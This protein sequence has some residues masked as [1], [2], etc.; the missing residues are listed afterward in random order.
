MAPPKRNNDDSP[1]KFPFSPPAPPP[2]VAGEG[3]GEDITDAGLEDLIAAKAKSG[4]A[5]PPP[6]AL[7]PPARAG[8]RRPSAKEAKEK[9]S[10]KPETVPESEAPKRED[11][12]TCSFPGLLKILFPEKSFVPTPVPV[13]VV[14]LSSGGALVEIHDKSKI[15]RDTPL[16]NRFFELKVA[17]PEI[18]ILRGSIAWSDFSRQNVLLGLSCFE[19]T[20]ELSQLIL[21]S[22]TAAAIM[23]GP[24][25]LPTPV[26]DPFPPVSR[27]ETIVLTGTAPEA[28]EVLVRS[29]ERRFSAKVVKGRFEIKLEIGPQQENHFN[30]RSVAGQRRSRPIPIRIEYDRHT[31]RNRF[32]FNATRGND[33]DGSHIIK[34]ELSGSVRQAERI[35]YRFSQL[36]AISEHVNFTAELNSPGTFDKRLFEALRA[37][38]AVLAADTDRNEMATKL[39]DELL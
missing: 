29:D 20:P 35:L 18:P 2:L 8:A 37:E 32:L 6:P 34:V 4:P 13:R 28:I 21:L 1:A 38:G 15:D 31:G 12:I 22:D 36:L 14:N 9:E 16:P 7:P 10:Q 27:E 39:L 33:K 17:H 19:R 30:L 24:P 11:R 26:L 23:E 5:I 25:P 3:H